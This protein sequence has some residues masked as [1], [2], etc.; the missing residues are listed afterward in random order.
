MDA[1]V[2]D[3]NE[4]FKISNIQDFIAKNICFNC[5]KF[6]NISPIY[7]LQFNEGDKTHISPIC[8]RCWHITKNHQGNKWR[9]MVYEDT[10]AFMTFPCSFKDEGCDLILTW[11]RVLD[12]EMGCLNAIVNCPANFCRQGS[13]IEF[14]CTWKGNTTQLEKHIETFH[15]DSIMDPPYFEQLPNTDQIYFTRVQTKLA[16]IIFLK[17]SDSKYY[18][19]VLINGSNV[20]S[21]YYQYQIELKDKSEKNSIILRKSRLEPFGNLLTTLASEDKMIE[22]NLKAIQPMI[23][24]NPDSSPIAARFGVVKKNKREMQQV[25]RE[26]GVIL[27]TNKTSAISNIHLLDE[28]ILS[29]LECP[30]CNEF[31]IP[32]IYICVNG[33]SLC[34]ECLEK[35]QCCP[36]CRSSL[37]NKTRNF[38]VEKLTTKVHYP[39]KNREIGCGI[40]T[41]SDK[42]REHER[43][44]DLTDTTC[45]LKC[46]TKLTRL[47]IYNHLNEVHADNILKINHIHTRDVHDKKENNFAMYAFGDI[48]RFTIKSAYNSP[49]K[50]NLQ[51][52]GKDQQERF[53]YKLEIIDKSDLELHVTVTSVVQPLSDNPM[54]SNA[55]SIPWDLVKPAIFDNK[56]FC[57]RINVFVIKKRK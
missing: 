51:Q 33:H 30:V 25:A 42:I 3:Y 6:L 24:K 12:H 31:M 4:A 34:N 7:C 47:A 16:M 10:A 13:K 48:F 21:Q 38:T 54:K 11:D 18:C 28:H 53:R 22:V 52:L 9:Q 15:R 50:F 44:C 23:R 37:E 5:N 43:V 20:E 49:L 19:T 8:G 41:T 46:G 36:N 27:K 56:L 32:P 2:V 39:C 26:N 35:V 40:S 17:D 57:F 45:I 1:D 55:V 14:S 29:E